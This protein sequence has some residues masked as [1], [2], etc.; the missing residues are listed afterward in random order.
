MSRKW[1]VINRGILQGASSGWGKL[2]KRVVEGT[3]EE[4]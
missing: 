2:V 3:C 4:R 1:Q